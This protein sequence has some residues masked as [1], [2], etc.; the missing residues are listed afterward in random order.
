VDRGD[1]VD[2][3]PTLIIAVGGINARRVLLAPSL[4]GN[5]DFLELRARC[6]K[7]PVARMAPYFAFRLWGAP[8]T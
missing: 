6:F 7:W 4:T 1:L 2:E 3:K 8:I 5:N